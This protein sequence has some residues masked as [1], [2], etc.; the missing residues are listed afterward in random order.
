MSLR[1]PIRSNGY[2]FS[3]AGFALFAVYG[4][5]LPFDYV[6]RA[7][8]EAWDA[9]RWVWSHRVWPQSRADFL[10]NAVLGFPLGYCLIAAIRTGLTGLRSTV[11]QAFGLLAGCAVFAAAIEFVQLWFPVRSSAASDVIAQVLGAA[12]GMAAWMFVGE[13][14]TVR[15][16][17]AWDSP[18]YGGRTGRALCVMALTAL[19]IQT[20]PWDFAASPHDWMKKVRGGITYVPF[21]DW[22]EATHRVQIQWDALESIVLYVPLGV[23]AFL[24]SGWFRRFRNIAISGFV[25]GIAVEACQWPVMSRHP[26]STDIIRDAL[27]LIVGWSV[28]RSVTVQHMPLT[29]PLVVWTGFLAAVSCWP[30][31]FGAA[32]RHTLVSLEHVDP[33]FWLGEMAV[34]L[35]AFAPFGAVSGPRGIVWA[36]LVSFILEF[37]QTFVPG[38]FGSVTDLVLAAAGGCVGAAFVRRFG[39]GWTRT[40][41]IG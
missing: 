5:L 21:Q 23:M 10:A 38:R 34:K 4:S 26:S 31:A 18:H 13:W 35:L 30:H 41:G 14:L 11:V 22:T 33:L 3:A 27:A 25:L 20:L 1:A 15:L 6:P 29:I 8:A 24:T 17:T 9:Y 2:A 36:S 39:S 40:A 16:R 28:A 32:H 12:I 19:A 37:G 7:W